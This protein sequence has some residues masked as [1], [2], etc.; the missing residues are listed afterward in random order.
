MKRDSF[1]NVNIDNKTLETELRERL[2]KGQGQ[3]QRQGQR[4]TALIQMTDDWLREIDA[5]K[6]VGAVL[7]ACLLTLM[8]IVCF[9]KNILVMAL[10]PLLYFG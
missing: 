10:H 4:S 5:K 9:W 8:I 6:I 2:R 1:G 3:R 7:L